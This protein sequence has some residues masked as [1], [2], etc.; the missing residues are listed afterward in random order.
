[1][2]VPSPVAYCALSIKVG[3]RNEHPSLNGIAHMTEHMLF[4]GTA[5]RSSVSINNYLESLGGELNAY[6]T[7]EETVIQATVLKED[8]S[9][10][11]ELLCD[12]AFNS[13]FPE[14]E[15]EKEKEVILEEIKSY[16][17]S[18]SELIFDD[19]EE[20]L[21]GGHPLAGN[22][23]GTPKSLKRISTNDIREFTSLNYRPENM[24]FS[25]VADLPAEKCEK[26]VKRYFG[27]N[28][29]ISE[30]IDS[31]VA[32]PIPPCIGGT[33]KVISKR[34]YQTH[35][36]IGGR[37][38]SFYDRQRLPLA[39]LTNIIGGPALNS[40]LNQLLREKH[41]LAYSVDASYTP[42]TDTGV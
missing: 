39:I 21:F 13:R 6:T 8:L 30:S 40:K 28:E 29:K 33:V 5:T 2:A 10:A 27:N 41:A 17:D 26:L 9:K 7:K 12:L 22:I 16:K 4:K 25:I 31:N 32:V 24:S 1:M 14:K 18:P 34:S 37:A 23:L 11:V 15:L 35:C 19:F 36:V 42:F 20:E 38:Y 3:T